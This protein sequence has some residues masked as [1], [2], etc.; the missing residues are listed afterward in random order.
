MVMLDEFH[1]NSYL[2]Y[3]TCLFLKNIYSNW[4]NLHTEIW[5]KSNKELFD[6][7]LVR[8]LWKITKKET[9]GAF[10]E[11]IDIQYR[12]SYKTLF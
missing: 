7:N 11:E 4:M 10:R 5:S 9:M 3:I 12:E 6:M 1:I 2:Y 8:H